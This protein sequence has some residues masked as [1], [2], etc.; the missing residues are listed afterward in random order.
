MKNQK[1]E[2]S[3]QKTKT[4]IYP[5]AFEKAFDEHIKRVSAYNTFQVFIRDAIKEKLQRQGIVFE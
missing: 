2:D 1:T 5:V 3:G 4:I